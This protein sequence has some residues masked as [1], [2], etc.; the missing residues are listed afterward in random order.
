MFQ[1]NHLAHA[2]QPGLHH[3]GHRITCR[4]RLGIM[5]HQPQARQPILPCQ[6]R[7]G[8]QE[9]RAAALSVGIYQIEVGGI[10]SG[11]LRHLRHIQTPQMHDPVPVR[12][13]AHHLLIR[14]CRV[15]VNRPR[16][17]SCLKSYRPPSQPPPIGGRGRTPSP[18]GG[19]LGRGNRGIS[20][21]HPH[22]VA[23]LAQPGRQRRP[24]PLAVSEDQPVPRRCHRPHLIRLGHD[25]RLPCVLRH[26]HGREPVGQEERLPRRRWKQRVIRSLVGKAPPAI[27]QAKGQ[28]HPAFAL[29]RL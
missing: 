8:Q 27:R 6:Q 25:H 21:H 15:R 13:E 3:P 22:L 12:A 10:R 28:I 29:R 23:A 19:G 26:G 1:V 9:R 24:H 11:I 14:P 5:R 16:L 18:I 7:L 17:R 20:V 2:P 4:H